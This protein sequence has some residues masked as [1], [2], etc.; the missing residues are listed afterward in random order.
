MTSKRKQDK[1][2]KNRGRGRKSEGV[3]QE[4]EKEKENL[5]HHLPLLLTNVKNCLSSYIHSSF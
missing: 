1:E 4:R 2:E 3:E 5:E